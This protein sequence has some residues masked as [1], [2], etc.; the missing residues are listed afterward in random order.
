MVSL[1]SGN[2]ARVLATGLS[3]VPALAFVQA[4][5]AAAVPVCEAL[6][7]Y[8]SASASGLCKSLSPASQNLQVCELSSANPDIHTTFNEATPLHITV[9]VPKAAE[10]KAVGVRQAAARRPAP[11]G[12]GALGEESACEGNATFNG[13][14]PGRLG[15]QKNAAICG[16]N[17]QSY[18]ARLNAVHDAGD[19]I[20]AFTELQTKGK[21]SAAVANGYITLAKKNNCK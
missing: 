3:L 21:L 14:W 10:P 13:N 19:P 1:L 2:G 8:A 5:P 4:S 11:G 20:A 15:L 6:R 17:V 18:L 7:L 12:R 16:V 9:R